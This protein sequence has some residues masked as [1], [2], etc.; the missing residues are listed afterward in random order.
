MSILTLPLI[1]LLVC[2]LANCISPPS[3]PDEKFD[4]RFTPAAISP[5]ADTFWFSVFTYDAVAANDA[6]PVRLPVTV[7]TVSVFVPG[8]YDNEFAS[9]YVGLLPVVLSVNVT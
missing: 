8:L 7:T 2:G 1:L 5:D 6:V 4:T 9:V 3:S